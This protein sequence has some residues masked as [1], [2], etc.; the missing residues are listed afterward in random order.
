MISLMSHMLKVFLRIIH[1]RIRAK[2]E[3]DLDN[4]QFGFRNTFGTREALFGLNIL[5]QKC[6][7]HQKDVFAC[8]MDY[9]K[10]FDRVLHNTFI[11]LLCQVGVD[12]KD[13]RVIKNLY[14]Q[15]KAE[16]RKFGNPKC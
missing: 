11:D 13:I 15:Q 16:I 1:A 8:F 12:G 2:C 10:A 6:R 7:D 4:A 5:L 14:W 3:W 9:E